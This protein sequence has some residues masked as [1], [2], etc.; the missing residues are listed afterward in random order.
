M[1]FSQKIFLTT[2]S[3]VTISINLI[4][5][6][7]INNNYKTQ[8]DAKIENNITLIYNISDKLKLYDIY[9]LNLPKEDSIYYE[10]S[11]NNEIIYTNLFDKNN[12][13]DK[14]LPAEENIKSINLDGI[15]YTS[16][17][18][19]HKYNVILAQDMSQIY[20]IRNEQISFFIKVSIAFSF[21]VA[22]VLYII[23]F[24]LT[25]K[26]KTLDKTVREI[27]DG[28]Y[29]AR[30]K[31]IGTDEVGSLALSFNKMAESIEETINEI[32]KVSENRQNFINNIT[33]EIRTPLTSIIGYSSLIKSGRID[34][35]EKIIEYNNKIYE[36]GNYLNLM[37]QRLV[38]IVLLDNKEI[39]L[40]EI[41]VSKIL[42]EIIENIEVGYVDIKFYKQIADNITFLCDK[43]LL[44]SLVTNVVKNAIMAY[45][46]NDKKIVS[47]ILE[48]TNEKNVLLKITDTG[49]GMT[50][51]QLSKITDQFY[52]L[53]QDRNR[54]I[55]GMGLGLPLCVKI[56][57]VLNGSMKIES[58]KG[59]GTTVKIN[60]RL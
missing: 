9:N 52:T 33:H 13:K 26:L 60:F 46:E 19:D 34:E 23:T 58:K 51:E 1:K 2:F 7:I 12:I 18:I 14:I 3:L 50:E 57:D 17:K 54:E 41:N 11:T 37:V 39:N 47:I 59:Q 44:H 49:R 16:T 6:I 35:K 20:E 32:N 21:I 56:C 48:Q 5:I 29:A 36:E 22:F 40:E 38:D 8:I 43:I 24:L 4:G 45:D 10:I 31:K 42:N 25:K 55:S 15:L 27:S 53:N 28:N 30:V